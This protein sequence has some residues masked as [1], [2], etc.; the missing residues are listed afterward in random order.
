MIIK[1]IALG[2]STGIFC[3]GFCFPIL[4]PFIFSRQEA[5]IKSSSVS[6]GL[7]LFGRLSGY[8]F[9]G[10]AA[11]MVGF[12]SKDILSIHRIVIP[13]LFILLGSIMVIYGLA[14]NLPNLKICCFKKGILQKPKNL[15]FIGFLAGINICPPF[16]LAISYSAGTKDIVKSLIFF[17]FFFLATSVYFV[18]LI[19]SSVISRFENVRVA[20]RMTSI[21][22]GL[23]FI[24]QGFMA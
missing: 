14:E 21:I 7:F 23:W 17:F 8:L 24:Y 2:F 12:Y 19:F 9:V 20:A 5:S 1:A 6:L 13:Y 4:I 3:L 22:V 10:L 16:I 11:G 15:F 18:P